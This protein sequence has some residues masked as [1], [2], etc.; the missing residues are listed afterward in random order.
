MIGTEKI[1]DRIL[2]D[3]RELHEKIL[4]DARAEARSII[5][6]AQK[7]AME[8][9]AVINQKAKEEAIQIKKRYRAVSSLDDRKNILK[10]RQEI[11]NE[12]FNIALERVSSLPESE[13]IAFIEKIL[14][15]AARDDAGLVLFNEKDK[16]SLGDSFIQRI[17]Q[18]LSEAGRNASLNLAHDVLDSKGGFILKYGDMEVN[19]TL[20]VL[21]AMARPALEQEVASIL[22][23]D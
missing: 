9:A 7:E 13:Y 21:F 1:K 10:V 6:K 5:E 19:C 14:L 16:R 11:V 15:K 20:E 12:A 2:S 4:E 18:K 8:K 3:A 22:F 17:N 23:S